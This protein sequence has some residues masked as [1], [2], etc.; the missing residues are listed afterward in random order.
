MKWKYRLAVESKKNFTPVGP[1]FETAYAAILA[2]PAINEK[3]KQDGL[4]PVV[5]LKMYSGGRWRFLYY[6]SPG[7]ATIARWLSSAADDDE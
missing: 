3:R 5:A 4:K 1:A 6:L 7:A 2:A